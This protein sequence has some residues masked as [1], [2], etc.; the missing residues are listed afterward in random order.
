[1]AGRQGREGEWTKR[2]G[3]GVGACLWGVELQS[4]PKVTRQDSLIVFNCAL[5]GSSLCASAIIAVIQSR[6]MDE[7]EKF[8]VAAITVCIQFS[9]VAMSVFV[10]HQQENFEQGAPVTPKAMTIVIALLV[11]ARMTVVK[12]LLLFNNLLY[13]VATGK[14]PNPYKDKAEEDELMNQAIKRKTEKQSAGEMFSASERNEQMHTSKGKNDKG[15]VGKG[16]K[17]NGK[18][19]KAKGKNDSAATVL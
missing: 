15:K 8:N 11:A 18:K 17:G 14:V 12:P 2:V 13:K 5:V 10:G 1:M 19:G 6:S 16:K 7:S 3:G 4:G 9:L